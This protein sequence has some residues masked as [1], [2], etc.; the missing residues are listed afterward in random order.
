MY[1]AS[2]ECINALNDTRRDLRFRLKIDNSLEIKDNIVEFE[3]EEGIL[4][5]ENFELGG[6]VASSFN[7]KIKDIDNSYKDFDFNNKKLNVEIGIILDDETMEYIQMGIFTIEEVQRDKNEITLKAIDNMVKLE[8][9]YSPNLTYPTTVRDMALEICNLCEIELQ[10][11]EFENNDYV[12]DS[13]IEFQTCRNVVKEIAKLSGGFAKIN[14]SGKLEFI[15]LTDTDFTIDK[16][17]YIELE[18]SS[19][20]SVGSLIITETDFPREP[21]E[22]NITL[23]PFTASWFGDLRVEVGDK[24]KLDDGISIEETIITNQVITFN[25]GLKYKSSCGGLNEQQQETQHISNQAKTNQ[26]FASEIKQNVKEISMRVKNDELENIVTQNADSWGLSINGKLKN[27]NC[28]FN[29]EG[30]N[31]YNGSLRIYDKSMDA[32]NKKVV[33][34]ADNTGTLI[35]SGIF[36]QTDANGNNS[37]EI[38]NNQLKVYNWKKKGDYVG[39]L[40]ALVRN[41][42]EN[43]PMIGLWNDTDSAISIGYQDTESSSIYSYIILDKYNVLGDSSNYPILFYLPT[44]FKNDVR[45]EK[46][47][48]SDTED[49]LY[50]RGLNVDEEANMFIYGDNI[51]VFGNFSATGTKNRIV[52][53]GNNKMAKLNAIESAECVF[54]DFGEAVVGEDGEITIN[55]DEIFLKT[56][57]T[58]YPYQVFLQPYGEGSVYPMERNKDNF[59]IKGT[60]GLSFGWRIVCKQKGYEEVRL[61]IIENVFEE[62]EENERL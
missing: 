21:V 57:N 16:N 33:F 11:D 48:F 35:F 45:L 55:I 10:T 44:K 43:K 58:D 29:D 42:D 50:I 6:G 1:N 37:V 26:K 24:V 15:K 59:V 60:P 27:V 9:D 32:D 40:G 61:D 20:F 36:Q 5:D 12:V 34:G 54:E 3:L 53:I 41:Q 14:R 7:V 49:K 51:S 62:V 52:D 56:V 38:R 23:T 30:M 31:I 39:S 2:E 25:G 22:L 18:K 28:L 19:S 17:R 47:N 46:I 4:P 13:K 8:K